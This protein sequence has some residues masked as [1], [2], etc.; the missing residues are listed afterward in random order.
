MLHNYRHP[1]HITALLEQLKELS[2]R[3]LHGL[4]CVNGEG[5]GMAVLECYCAQWYNARE[6]LLYSR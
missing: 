1:Q 2:A 6:G 3:A 5:G 4:C